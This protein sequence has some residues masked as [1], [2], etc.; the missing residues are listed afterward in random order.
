MALK[1]EI[2]TALNRALKNLVGEKICHPD[3]G[4]R[5]E[6]TKKGTRHSVLVKTYPL[7]IKMIY[8]A[9]KRIKSSR[10]YRIEIE[11]DNTTMEL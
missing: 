1:N 7:K 8:N 6:F 9:I 10:L 4:K 5:I 2:T 3:I 11:K